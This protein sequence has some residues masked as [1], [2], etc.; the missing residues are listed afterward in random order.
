[1]K[2]IWIEDTN[3]MWVSLSSTYATYPTTQSIPAS[4]HANAPG[5]DSVDVLT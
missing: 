3:F 5:S 4:I 2:G 1:M